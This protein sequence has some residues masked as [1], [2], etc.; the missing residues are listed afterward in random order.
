MHQ[1]IVKRIMMA[2]GCDAAQKI[3]YGS[4]PQV[5]LLWNLSVTLDNAGV[6]LMD[7]FRPL[8]RVAI[9]RSAC[10][11]SELWK[12]SELEVLV[13]IDQPWQKKKGRPIEGVGFLFGSL[14]R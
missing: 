10:R 9:E 5:S 7:L 11:T 4:P 8:C 2:N 13:R 6:N 12:Q 14:P 3:A 1:V